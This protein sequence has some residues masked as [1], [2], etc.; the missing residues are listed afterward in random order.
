MLPRCTTCTH[1]L[2]LTLVGVSQQGR[3]E[4]RNH[5]RSKKLWKRFE[6]EKFG[7]RAERVEPSS[8]AKPREK[9]MRVR[10]EPT[11]AITRWPHVARP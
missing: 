7:E 9:L 6:Q 11:V 10:S 2:G 3:S 5:G 1:R 8:T 4:S